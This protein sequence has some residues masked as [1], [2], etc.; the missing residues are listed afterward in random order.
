M[1]K[2]YPYRA[3]LAQRLRDARRDQGISYAALGAHADVDPA[4]ALRICRG[5]FV[6][7][8]PGVLRVC[9]TLRVS[10]DQDLVI[11]PA[12]TKSA[13][14]NQLKAELMASWDKTDE[15]ALGL[16]ALLRAARGLAK[17]ERAR[18]TK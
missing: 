14:G 13:A 9:K 18:R 1:A 17:P 15:G 4:Q 6:T 11:G 3:Q 10:V 2:S 8:N 16:I 12:L 7:L 5:Q